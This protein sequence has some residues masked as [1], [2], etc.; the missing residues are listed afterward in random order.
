VWVVGHS[1]VRRGL[2]HRN[3]V[4]AVGFLRGA[5]VMPTVLFLLVQTFELLYLIRPA[6]DQTARSHT[7]FCILQ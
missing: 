5:C 1:V 3:C 2:F 4:R 6:Q 7:V